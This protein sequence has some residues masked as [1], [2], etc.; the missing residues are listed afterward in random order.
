[1]SIMIRKVEY[2]FPLGLIVKGL[3]NIPDLEFMRMFEVAESNFNPLRL[4]ENMNDKKTHNDC[5]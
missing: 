1:M 2:L 5:L 3:I 4:L